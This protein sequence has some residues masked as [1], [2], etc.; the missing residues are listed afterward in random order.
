MI[1]TT[2]VNNLPI[3]EIENF[4]SDVE[5]DTLLNSRVNKFSKAISHYPKYY[6]NNDRLVE[7][8]LDLATKLFDRLNSIENMDAKVKKEFVSLND[9]IR[10]CSY[11][12]GQE[13]S[14]H[15]D[16]I[17][18]PNDQ[19]KSKL[20]FLLYLNGT[21]EFHGGETNFFKEKMDVEPIAS[22]SP[23][24][25]MLVVFDHRIWHQGA[26]ISDGT[27]Y[28]L[29]SD[30]IVENVET[31]S[32]H[33]GYIWNLLLVNP[34][35]ILSCGRDRKVKF[36]NKNL[37]ELNSYCFHD[38]SVLKIAALLEGE[39]VSCSR[40]F[41]IKKW[42]VKGQLYN[43][44]NIGEMILSILIV[45]RTYILAAGT[46]GKIHLLDFNLNILKSANIHTGWVW[47]MKLLNSTSIVSCSDDGTVK[48][49]CVLTLETELVYSNL[50]G[51]FSLNTE[52]ENCVYVGSKDGLLIEVS[53]DN[54]KVKKVKL[55]EDIIRSIIK[56][57]DTFYTCSEDNTVKSFDSKSSKI[58]DLMRQ[59]NFI[60]DII[61][62]NKTLYAAGYDG[63]ISKLLL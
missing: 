6:R 25:G 50:E 58:N 28:I 52:N 17:Y 31:P 40:D 48:K 41:T 24:K 63:N 39:Y 38:N 37:E 27:K 26:S 16:G 33:K 21:E 53:L 43:S 9:R 34:N 45:D 11:R 54:F 30:I 18:Y 1:K 29:R 14:K 57:N 22:I 8:N 20:T 5:V 56:Y 62:S 35:L 3:I 13:F 10:F 4:L 36:W 32:H 15:Q 7:D 59:D 49:T 55:H 61:I 19:Q 51:L 60:Q 42:D 23:K 47:D 2:Y 46:S 44:V 12:S